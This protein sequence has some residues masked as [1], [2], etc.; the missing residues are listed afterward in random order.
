VE[1]GEEISGGLIVAR[2]DAAELF[3]FAEEILD[4]VACLVERLIDLAGRCSVLPRRDHGGFSGTRQRLENALISIIGLVGDQDLGSHLRQQRIGSGE[5][6]NLSRGQKEAQ[7]I[8]ESV[9]QS[10][11]LVLNPPLLRPIA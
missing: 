1:G 8:A 5:I 4:Q 2:G 3:K 10:V 7:R 6:V 11:D 9:D